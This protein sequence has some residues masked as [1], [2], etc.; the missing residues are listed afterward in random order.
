MIWQVTVSFLALTLGFLSTMC[1][2][3]LWSISLGLALVVCKCAVRYSCSLK[4]KRLFVIKVPVFHAPKICPISKSESWQILTYTNV[5]GVCSACIFHTSF[6]YLWDCYS[7]QQK[8]RACNMSPIYMSCSHF[9][10]S[11]SHSL[12][13]AVILVKGAAVRLSARQAKNEI[14]LDNTSTLTTPNSCY[15]V[16][17]TVQPS[18]SQM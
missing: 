4:D 7:N 18:L 9:P 2:I 15:P 12:S 3:A 6:I 5:R 8:Y 16:Y 14:H 10:F 11:P 1:F 13:S 17:K